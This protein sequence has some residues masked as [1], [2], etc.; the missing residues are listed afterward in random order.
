MFDNS[1]P[2]DVGVEKVDLQWFY[3]PVDWDCDGDID[4]VSSGF[5]HEL[6][7][8]ENRSG[9]K[10]VY[11]FGEPKRMV[12]MDGKEIAIVDSL[13]TIRVV[14]WDNDGDMD[15]LWGSEAATVGLLENVAGAGRVPLLRQSVFLQQ[16]CPVLDAGSISVPAVV[17]WDEDGDDD[18]IVSGSA[19]LK[20][21]ETWVL[22]LCRFGVGVKIC[23]LAGL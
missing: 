6:Y 14:D 1:R 16:I 9:E 10:G 17:D 21:Y 8:Y 12:T 23:G 11:D 7:Y 22:P 15:V 2:V 5:T 18:M 19:S 20:Y 4:L 13:I 3:V